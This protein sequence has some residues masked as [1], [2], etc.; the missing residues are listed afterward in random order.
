MARTFTLRL[1]S[2][3]H[4]DRASG[5]TIEP[6]DTVES[7]RDLRKELGG[8]D[9]WELV[10]S[11]EE[12][13]A[14]LKARLAILEGRLS[15]K[16]RE[17]L[18]GEEPVEEESTEEESVE[19]IDLSKMTISKLR[20]Y[21]ASLDPPVDLATCSNKDEIVNEIRAHLDAA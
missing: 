12:S 7:K 15:A 13:V 17:E 11:G 16:D 21:A 8:R 3:V 19:E 18:K 10:N 9:R 14:D 4:Y 6:G 1:R 5:R 2:G 20:K